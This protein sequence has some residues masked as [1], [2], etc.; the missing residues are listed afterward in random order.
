MTAGPAAA[1]TAATPAAGAHKP[2]LI[3][4]AIGPCRSDGQLSF[5]IRSSQANL[6]NPSIKG[7]KFVDLL[8]Y[9]QVENSLIYDPVN[10]EK[11]TYLPS[12]K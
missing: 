7:I 2:E 5:N 1:P 6:C 8:F 3:K 10:K 4:P 9:K 11:V 12:Y